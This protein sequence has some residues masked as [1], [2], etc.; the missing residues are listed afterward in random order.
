MT[1]AP[2]DQFAL[3]EAPLVR[4]AL[5]SFRRS[6]HR[7]N[8]V[9]TKVIFPQRRDGAIL[10]E[11]M[12]DR[13]LLTEVGSG[14]ELSPAGRAVSE[15]SIR[16]E[17]TRQRA[18]RDLRNVLEAVQQSN[19]GEHAVD[20]IEEV[21]VSGDYLGTGPVR[22]VD[23]HFKL[24]RRP[25]HR[26]TIDADAHAKG[27]LKRLR[28]RQPRS[29]ASDQLT[30]WLTDM[31]IFGERR[32]AIFRS[33]QFDLE[34]LKHSG[35]ACRRLFEF[36]LGLVRDPVLKCHPEACGSVQP[37]DQAGAEIGD[38][39]PMDGTWASAYRSWGRVSPFGLYR[40]FSPEALALF[41]HIPEGLRVIGAER[42]YARLDWVP[43]QF[44]HHI[45]GRH[46]LGIM[47]HGVTNG[48]GCILERQVVVSENGALL[49]C[50]IADVFGRDAEA[51]IG[52]H[53]RSVAAVVALIAAADGERLV[54]R[55]IE[56]LWVRPVAIELV[57]DPS[58]A[59]A[60]YIAALAK[61]HLAERQVNIEP[62]GWSGHQVT[63]D[64]PDLQE[65]ER[66]IQSQAA[67][68][69]DEWLS[70]PVDLDF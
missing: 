6:P 51:E 67:L 19:D 32:Q 52:P 8:F 42:A 28:A 9:D 2:V 57:A 45:D 60:T 68:E 50:V 29:M 1:S 14:H 11:E 58:N 49:S 16:P 23:L 36:R 61:R 15:R 66:P 54:R 21:W 13:G 69:R 5:H 63:V 35:V 64:G 43:E 46:R 39:R 31:L 53:A 20:D 10:F 30:A 26:E 3:F 25:Q 27:A 40:G 62:V 7:I 55:S 44:G 56:D 22:Q 34:A 47:A 18:D 12:L 38:V 48:L 65:P 4:A 37:L 70:T 33:A 59:I 17:T 41:S 24:R